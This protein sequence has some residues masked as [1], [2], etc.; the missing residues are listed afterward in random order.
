M[1]GILFRALANPT[2]LKDLTEFLERDGKQSIEKEEKTF[3]FEFY[4]D[5][6]NK[7]ALYVY[8]AYE[9]KRTS[10]STSRVICTKNGCLCKTSA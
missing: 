1:Y 10:K 4:H 3:R 5:P 7:N 2:G 6:E 8:E 9:T